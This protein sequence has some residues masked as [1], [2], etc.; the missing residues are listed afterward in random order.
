MPRDTILPPAMLLFH[1]QPHVIAHTAQSLMPCTLHDSAFLFFVALH[2]IAS[3]YRTKKYQFKQPSICKCNDSVCVF[4]FFVYLDQSKDEDKN[5]NR[6][7][8]FVYCTGN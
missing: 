5:A 4:V 6:I 2:R 1:L 7:R 3:H 8:I